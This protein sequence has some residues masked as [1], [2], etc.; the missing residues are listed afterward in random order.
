MDFT[1]IF[2]NDQN[3]INLAVSLWDV[4]QFW[5]D[6]IDRDK[7]LTDHEINRC[8]LLA[9][10]E[11]PKN[12]IYLTMP[13]LPYH[14]YNVFL[15][16]RDSTEMEKDLQP[17]DREKCYMLRA[18]VYDLFVLIAA[19]LYGDDWAKEIGVYVRRCYGETVDNFMGVENA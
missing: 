11:I 1:R 15:R 17:N 18:G 7:T 8:M 9:M 10:V 2:K 3:A 5:D 6:L 14:I 16:W 4:C 19:H 12:P 13:E